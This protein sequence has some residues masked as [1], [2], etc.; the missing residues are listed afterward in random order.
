MLSLSKEVKKVALLYGGV[1]KER[2]VSI[3]SGKAVEKALKSL[4]Y[5][6]KSFDPADKEKFIN[7]LLTFQPNIAFIALHGKGG[8]D[9]QIQSVLDFYGIKYTG[10]D[11]T[12][13]AICFNKRFTKDILKAN[14][15]PVPQDVSP[16]ELEFPVVVKP[17]NEGSS[18]G[19]FIVK[20][21]NE[22][23]EALNMLKDYEDI[24]VERFIPGRE[25]TVGILNGEVLPIVEI[26]VKNGFYD[27]ENKYIS[28]ETEYLC[29]APLNFVIT[30]TIKKLAKKTYEVLKC[31]G[32]VRIDFIL[33]EDNQPYVLEV[34]TIPGMTDH[35]LL[36]KAANAAGYSFEELVQKI[37][38]GSL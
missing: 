7:Q 22:L 13:S 37:I 29:P 33:S 26:K 25:L 36:P 17:V 1:S 8:E 2:D 34:N 6:V 35:S 12:T 32:A 11:A 4:G 9:G 16:D 14:N 30:E 38:E 27:Y 10:C 21:K 19:V 23:Q 20:D 3:K 18:I 28:N 5:D 31:K 24:L 15:I